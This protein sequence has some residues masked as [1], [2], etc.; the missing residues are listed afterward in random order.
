MSL[1]HL[2]EKIVLPDFDPAEEIAKS[3]AERGFTVYRPGEVGWLPLSEWK[4]KSVC[5]V[6]GIYARLVLIDAVRPG[7]GAFGRMIVALRLAG[8]IPCVVDPTIE[9]AAALKRRGYRGR[10]VGTTFE[11]RETIWKA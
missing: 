7:S 11:D 6:N 5:S 3:E 10:E 1:A 2:I 8:L 4:S 9:F